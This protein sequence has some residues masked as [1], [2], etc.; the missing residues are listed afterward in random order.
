MAGKIS[1]PNSSVGSHLKT[2]SAFPVN[3]PKFPTNPGGVNLP[4]S[5][6]TTGDGGNKMGSMPKPPKSGNKKL[7]T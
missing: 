5:K 1:K 2:P 3:D 7:T 6:T 4:F